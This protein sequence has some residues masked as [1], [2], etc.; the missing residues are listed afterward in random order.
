MR[1][2][3][4]MQQAQR[5]ADEIERLHALRSIGLLDSAPEVRFDRLTRLVCRLL[6]V[7]T[8][9]VSLVDEDRQWFKSCVGLS[10]CELPR[11]TSFCGHAICEGELM[12]VPDAREDPRFADNPLV[13]GEPFIQFYAG[14]PVRSYSG[15]R[16][17]T[18]CAIDYQPRELSR[19]QLQDLEDL[20][21]LVER[22]IQASEL[23]V[24]DD[25]TG[26][27]NR[28]G[29][30]ALAENGLAH[31]RRNAIASCLL[32]ID[33][34]DFKAINDSHGHAAG[35]SVLQQFGRCLQQ[36]IRDTDVS[37]RIGGDEFVVLLT[38]REGTD[39]QSFVRRLRDVIKECDKPRVH[40]DD[41]LQWS[42]GVVCCEPE[43]HA[44][45]EDLLVEADRSM[46][47]R[48]R[49]RMPSV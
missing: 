10:E 20:A 22:E 24:T 38:G 1:I 16:I 18:L 40:G 29:F 17:G 41:E 39:P 19:E 13:T 44:T 30:A 5:P 36:S 48:K 32:Y 14:V 9:L 43:R 45:V 12:C 11:D 35:D 49:E 27:P 26:L 15:H 34:D 23:A 8:A 7:P 21:A 2:G 42:Y 4:D 33:L 46:Y 47:D 37:G 25:L 3:V 6:D 28:R 31:C